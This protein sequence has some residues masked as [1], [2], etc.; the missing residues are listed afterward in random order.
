MDTHLYSQAESINDQLKLIETEL[1][2]FLDFSSID[3]LINL[4]KHIDIEYVQAI[5]RE[6][7]YLAVYCGEGR[8][9]IDKLI[10]SKNVEQDIV[11]RVYKGIY[12]KCVLEF[13]SPKDEVWYED[14]RAS[15]RN[16]C[17]IDFQ[18]DPSDPI[19]QTME[20]IEPYFHKLREDLD[21]LEC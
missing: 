2:E 12:R 16:K 3:K 13:F 21:Y 14:S 15:Y 10:Q 11:D 9:A 6:F 5:F 1:H 20:K 17:S 4:N 8:N 18:T 7:R 19:V